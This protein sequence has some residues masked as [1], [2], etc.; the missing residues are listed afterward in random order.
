MWNRALYAWKN[1]VK[2]CADTAPCQTAEAPC[3]P[4]LSIQLQ[5]QVNIA[6]RKYQPYI[7]VDVNFHR[8]VSMS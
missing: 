3:I 7:Q 5:G 2:F 1:M 8:D 6:A 4:S